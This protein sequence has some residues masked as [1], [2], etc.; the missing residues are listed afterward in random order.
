[1]GFPRQEYWNC[2]HFPTLG[3]LP[4]PGIKPMKFPES[5]AL[6][7]G[8]FSTQPVGTP[9]FIFKV[10]IIRPYSLEEKL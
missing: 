4:D 5:P 2:L 1:M 8:F 9:L 3:Y 10:G 7:G 6:T